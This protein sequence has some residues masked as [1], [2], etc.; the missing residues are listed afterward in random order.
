MKELVYYFAET[1]IEGIVVTPM[2]IFAILFCILGVCFYPIKTL[3]RFFGKQAI[4]I[5]DT[6]SWYNSTSNDRFED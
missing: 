4:R 6:W 5:V 2:F 3:R 1:I